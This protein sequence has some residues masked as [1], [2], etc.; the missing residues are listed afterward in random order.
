MLNLNTASDFV[1][2]SEPNKANSQYP[3]I[4][5]NKKDE[6]F[7]VWQS[8]ENGADVIRARVA[9]RVELIEDKYVEGTKI[10]GEGN[11]L[12]PRVT[13]FNDIAYATWTEH[14][15]GKWNVMVSSYDNGKWSEPHKI[16]SGEGEFY[17]SFAAEEGKKLWIF[18]TSHKGPEASTVGC[19]FD[20]HSWSDL[21]VISNE[22]R[23]YRPSACYD[24]KGNLWVTYDIYR[25]S[26]YSLVCKYYDG[27]KFSEEI[28]LSETDDWAAK[29]SISP[30][31]DGASISWYEMGS[32]ASFSYWSSEISLNSNGKVDKKV[33][34]INGARDWYNTLHQVTGKDGKL[35][36]MYNWGQ[37]RM[38]L[39][40]KKDESGWSQPITFTSTDRNFDIRCKG[41]IDSDNYLWI[42]W[43]NA[44]GNGH[45]HRNAKILLRALDLKNI[46]K[47]CDGEAEFVQ[48]QFTLPIPGEKKLDKHSVETVKEWRSKEGIFSKYNILWGDIHGQSG[49]SDGLGEI[50]QY[51]HVAKVKSDLDFTSLTDHDCFPDAVSASEWEL[52][53]FYANANNVENDLVTFIS[54][55]WT[56]N[57]YKYDFGH[58]NIYYR[59]ND[60][61]A[62][63]STEENGYTP[64]RLFNS[65]KGKKAL[66]FPHHPSADWGMVSAA[67]D[68]FFNNK[69]HQRLVEVFSRHA[70]FEYD[71]K[72]KSKYTKNIN[73]MENS[74][75]LDALKRGYRLGFTAGSDSHQM[76]HGIEGGIVAV[77]SE[78]FNRESIFDCLYDRRTFATTG[79][80]ILMEF[81]I[82]GSPMGTEIKLKKG[83]KVHLKIRVLGTSNICE[84]RIMKNGD[85]FK[86][87]D[88]DDK[89][90]DLEMEDEHLNDTDWYYVEVKQID[91]HQ[92]W[93]S[94]IW[95]DTIEG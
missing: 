63:R 20:G 92:G 89:K 29:P 33:E 65:L 23:A 14:F 83:E 73:R 43:Q 85:V 41:A 94:P 93:A 64:D 16:F 9:S 28:T 51:Y 21:K 70:D 46:E 66:A 13:I 27:K 67:T 54:L 7:V 6:I 59:D 45:K 34:K 30:Y 24:N 22:G 60:G 62:I 77:Y 58:K 3:D 95:I 88:L 25:E 57:E 12:I 56:S 31:K 72:S 17:P 8:Y 76:E 69:E 90:I 75:A 52:M 87:F 71:P 40:V 11:A 49:M 86:T 36:F 78:G 53:K 10:S 47:L 80:R 38:H 37:R 50:D 5:I 44:E 42:I 39:R 19:S 1:T 32:G 81:S 61:E 91:D 48:E 82:N 79:A 55:E 4:A 2:L 84:L 68:W 15:E 18:W 26:K 35:Y 74:S